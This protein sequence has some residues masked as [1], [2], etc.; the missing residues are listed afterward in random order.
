MKK[1][2]VIFIVFS[3]FFYCQNLE[4]QS[5]SVTKRL[6][7]TSGSTINPD[8]I[9]S[10]N[11]VYCV[12]EDFVSSSNPEVIFKKSLDGGLTWQAPYRLTYN[13]EYSLYP[14]IAVDSGGKLI[15]A[16]QELFAGWHQIL[17]KTSSNGGMSWS[18]LNILTWNAASSYYPE[19]DIDS[20]NVVFI[21]WF[22][23]VSSNQEIFYKS[24]S[25][26][27]ANWSQ[28]GRLTWN[29]GYSKYPAVCI[30]SSD[31]LHVVWN[32]DT[33]GNYEIY[34]KKS[35]DGGA[36]WAPLKRLTWNSEG[37]YSPDVAV[38]SSSNIYVS[39]CEYSYGNSEVCYKKS[40]DGGVSWSSPQRLTWNSGTSTEQKINI[41]S[42]DHIHVVWS[43]NT[44]GNYEIYYKE[45]SDGG[46][47]WS[48]LKRLTWDS[49]PSKNPVVSTGLNDRVHVV[50]QD[51][52]QGGQDIYYKNRK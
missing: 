18:G 13:S 24:S 25:N 27:G 44:V 51:S 35:T 5:W 14:V 12:W 33:P 32:D 11:S 31:V 46:A 43:D 34:H 45:S 49:G 38:D 1:Y 3:S 6:T 30:D 37:S 8:M 4:S 41:G 48:V 7:W 21:F 19:I 40:T 52:I 17:Y 15:V 22:E 50:W 2:V 10:G 36:T 20:S 9:S 39:W 16:W 42:D 29:S 28:K 23:T 26:F 47:N